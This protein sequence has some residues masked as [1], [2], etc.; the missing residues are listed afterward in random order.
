MSSLVSH[1][2]HQAFFGGVAAAGFGVLFNCPP[3]LLWLC[4]GSGA[5]AL[6]ARTAGQDIGGWGLPTASL[7]AAFLLAVLN[8]LL[9]PPDSPRGSVLAVVGCIPMIPGSLA[10]KG[11]MNL[12]ELL[13]A[14]PGEGLQPA[15]AAVE[16]LIL[17]AFTLVGIGTAL[18]IPP[19]VFPIK[20]SEE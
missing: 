11:L 16:N 12:F 13:R 7:I 17:V 15:A 14:T 8:R 3:R 19:L 9:E 5:L 18:A 10:A 1:L 4:F 2:V 20:R 6:A